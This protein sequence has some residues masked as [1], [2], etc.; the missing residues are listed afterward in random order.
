MIPIDLYVIYEKKYSTN[1]NPTLYRDYSRK[2]RYLPVF[3]GNVNSMVD[4]TPSK[5]L[6]ELITMILLPL[7]MKAND[8]R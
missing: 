5:L 1:V 4:R 3:T 7:S 6:L 8:G 2:Y